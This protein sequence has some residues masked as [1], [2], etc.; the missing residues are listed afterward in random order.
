MA[1]ALLGKP[2]DPDIARAQQPHVGCQKTV[3][4]SGGPA[5]RRSEANKEAKLLGRKVCFISETGN[6]GW[7]HSC[8]KANCPH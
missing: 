6:W 5:A 8:P 2:Q 4:E 3:T 7:G 1:A